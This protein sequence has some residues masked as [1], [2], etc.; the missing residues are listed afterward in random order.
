MTDPREFAASV[1]DSAREVAI[2]E[3]S[4]VLLDS[5][6]KGTVIGG[7]KG[8][9]FLRPTHAPE[10]CKENV[11]LEFHDIA[12]YHVP[13][14]GGFDFNTWS[15]DGGVSYSLSVEKGIIRSTAQG[16]AIY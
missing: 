3:K 7:G 6:G 12:V 2:D 4:A 13:T 14:G 10:V 11:P 16:N 5:D 9:Y 8:A 15:G 1:R